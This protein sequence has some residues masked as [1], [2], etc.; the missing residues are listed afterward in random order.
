MHSPVIAT[1]GVRSLALR[2]LVTDRHLWSLSFAGWSGCLPQSGVL[3]D[4]PGGNQGCGV[5][6][7]L[8]ELLSTACAGAHQWAWH[9]KAYSV[10]HTCC[11]WRSAWHPPLKS[12]PCVA[13]APRQQDALNGWYG[14]CAHSLLATRSRRWW[15]CRRQSGGGLTATCSSMG[16]P[17]YVC[18]HPQHGIQRLCDWTVCARTLSSLYLQRFDL[19]DG[20]L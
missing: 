4:R 2:A 5:P 13:L 8:Q 18:F 1:W 9:G 7:V 10:L 15:P 3:Q 14:V 19:P 12:V 16:C 20:G 6:Q 11:Q 17:R